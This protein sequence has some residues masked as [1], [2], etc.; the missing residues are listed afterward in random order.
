MEEHTLEDT[1][2]ESF[3]EKPSGQYLSLIVMSQ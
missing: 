2:M 1:F 3:G